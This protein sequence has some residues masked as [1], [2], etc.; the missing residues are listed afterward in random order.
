MDYLVSIEYT[1]YHLWQIELLIQS[2]KKLGIED[3]LVIAIALNHIDQLVDCP[4]LINHP[5]KFMHFNMG[6]E[7]SLPINR[8]LAATIAIDK[9]LITQPFAIIHADMILQ[10]PICKTPDKFGILLSHDIVDDP[11]TLA[12]LNPCLKQIREESPIIPFGPVTVFNEIPIEFFFNA[13]QCLA[14]LLP[15][16]PKKA[17]TIAWLLTLHTYFGKIKYDSEAFADYMT[18]NTF[19]ANFIHY[20]YGLSPTFNKLY[21]YTQG[22]IT[23]YYENPYEAILQQEPST[24]AIRYFQSVVKDYLKENKPP[25]K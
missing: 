16:H 8:M 11:E 7:Y 25:H 19:H 2:F 5:R 22:A 18:Q 14:T 9:S 24:L 17:E 21:F 1:N 13:M 15:S 12:I 4:N 20:K 10:T 6:R 3:S 23:M